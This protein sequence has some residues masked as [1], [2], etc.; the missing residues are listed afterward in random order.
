MASNELATKENDALDAAADEGVAKSSPL[1]MLQNGEI[2]RSLIIILCLAIFLVVGVVLIYWGKEPAMRPLG[3][4][5]DNKELNT[6]ISYL[7]QHQYEYKFY[8]IQ[9]GKKNVITV[10]VEQY[11]KIVEGLIFSGIVTNDTTDGSDILLGDSSFGVSARKEEARLK[12]A[13]EK[14]IADM[15]KNNRKIQD[16]KV[17][18]AIPRRNVFVRTEQKPSASVTLKIGGSGALGPSEVDAIVDAVAASVQ[19]LEPSRV[20][21]IDQNGRLLNSGSMDETSQALRRATELQTQKEADYNRKIADILNP[22]LGF[23]NYR[24]LVEVTLDTTS[25]E[26][27]SKRYTDR[28]QIRSEQVTEEYSQGKRNS[29]VPGAVSNQ[30]PANSQIPEE[31]RQVVKDGQSVGSENERRSAVRNYELDTTI[32]HQSKRGGTLE[33]LS[34]SVAINY[35]D[36][37]KEDGTT[38]RVPLSEEELA[39]ISDLLAKGLGIDESR[40]DTLA[41]HSLKFFQEEFAPELPEPFYKT[42]AFEKYSKLGLSA[43]I[44]LCLVVFI[45]RPMVMTLINRKSPIDREAE[46]DPDSEIA[47]EGEDDLNLLVRQEDSQEALYNIENG[48]IKLPNL[49]KDEDLLRAVRALVS[50][51]PD[52]AAQVVK[53]WVSS[54]EVK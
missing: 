48:K 35:K 50:N 29:G 38:E 46:A 9:D 30:P 53:D 26:V 3:D 39:K 34:V 14:Q 4:Y 1:L 21:V 49:H 22:I 5:P 19:G 45:V 51:E 47:L 20:T 37:L 25:E 6:V 11:D 8:E 17:L 16:A 44:I 12:Y 13:Q 2:L 43:F 42:E 31:Y 36:V 54:V 7:K 40:G 33:R 15:L 27:T 28:P 24:P 52:L 23:G 32:S 41:V 10:S 18:L